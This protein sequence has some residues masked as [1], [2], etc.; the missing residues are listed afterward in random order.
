[1]ISNELIEVLALNAHDEAAGYRFN[2]FKYPLLP[3]CLY[4]S[5][6]QQQRYLLHKLT[7]RV[8]MVQALQESQKLDNK[9]KTNELL[10]DFYCHVEMSGRQLTPHQQ[11]LVDKINTN[12]NLAEKYLAKDQVFY[13][14]ET[15]LKLSQ[16]P[17]LSRGP[18]LR[19]GALKRG[20]QSDA[21]TARAIKCKL[22]LLKDRLVLLKQGK[23]EAERWE[24]QIRAISHLQ[25]KDVLV[26]HVAVP[27]IQ[28]QVENVVKGSQISMAFEMK[29][30]DT[31]AQKKLKRLDVWEEDAARHQAL[32]HTL[33]FL[34]AKSAELDIVGSEQAL[35]NH[36]NEVE[37]RIRPPGKEA[38]PNLLRSR[39]GAG[40]RAEQGPEDSVGP[41][42]DRHAQSE[43]QDPARRLQS[44]LHQLLNIYESGQKASFLT[45][46]DDLSQNPLPQQ[47]PLSQQQ[48]SECS[49]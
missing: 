25:Y 33:E 49:L 27:A 39:Q 7:S 36:E 22:T 47:N 4:Q 16:K 20:A 26:D 9:R 24:I 12:L 17:A 40:R 28:L 19:L 3:E 10:I 48:P 41:R 35:L 44:K 37:D 31:Q 14:S 13:Q 43:E 8:L 2:V 46:R 6:A 1:M 5:I 34:V 42:E 23:S 15:A 38:L 30:S 32:R 11:K 18:D 21:P 45:P 29:S